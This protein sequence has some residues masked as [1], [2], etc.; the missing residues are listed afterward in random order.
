MKAFD[1][2]FDSTAVQRIHSP[3]TKDLAVDA[4]Y[5]LYR[6]IGKSWAEDAWQAATE[7]AAKIVEQRIDP[8]HYWSRDAEE[9]AAKIR[10]EE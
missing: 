5:N 3:E 2:W 6:R 1:D 7:R 9:I 10:E 8:K 4:W